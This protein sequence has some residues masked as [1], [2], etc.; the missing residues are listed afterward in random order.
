MIFEPKYKIDYSPRGDTVDTF[1]QKVKAEID[2]IYHILNALRQNFP[3]S[4]DLNDTE[5]FQ[6]HVDTASK[7]IFVRNSSNESWNVIGDIDKDY[8]GITP[9]NIGAVKSD[10]TVGKFSAGNE[11]QKPTDAKTGDIFYD[12]TNRRA[13]YYT[14]TAW[15]IFLSLNFADLYD[16]ESYCVA[17]SE[18][19]YNGKNKIPRLDKNTGKGNFDITGSPEKILG[20]TIEVANLKDNDALIFDNAKQKFVNKPKDEITKADVSNSGGAN[21]IVQTNSAGFAQV[22]ISGSAA[23]IDGVQ[24]TTAGIANQKTLCYNSTYKRFEPADKIFAD[25]TGSAEKISG[26]GLDV[27]N[28]VDQQFLVYN[29]AQKKIIS[30]KKEYLHEGDVSSTG[31]VDKIVRLD[32]AGIVH[33]NL[34]GS[35]SKIGGVSVNA[36]GIKDGQVLAYDSAQKI[37]KPV[38]KDFVTEEKISE[39]GEIGKLVRLGSD[40]TIHANVDGSVSQ[41]DGV[42]FNLEK[43]SDGQLLSYSS[44]T[45]KIVPV[46]KDTNATS[47]NTITIDTSNLQNGQVLIYDAKNKKFVPAD[48]DFFTEKDVSSTGEVGKL[49]KVAANTP[50]NVNITGSASMIDGVNV[51]AAKPDDGDILVYRKSKNSFQ[52]ESKNTTGAGKS[53]TFTKGNETVCEYNGSKEIT[54]DIAAADKLET[55]RKIKLTGHAE[56][57][58]FF[59]GTSDVELN[60]VNVTTSLADEADFAKKCA[61]LETGRKISIGGLVT[62]AATEFDGTRDISLN[63]TK[64][65]KL[66]TPRNIRFTGDITGV[67]AFDGSEDINIPI[68]V[69]QARAATTAALATAA[70]TATQDSKGNN[71]FETYATKTELE[72]SK[73]TVVDKYLEDYAKTS[74]IETTYAK[75]SEVVK[76]SDLSTEVSKLNSASADKLSSAKKI[77]LTGAVKGTVNFD[78]SENVE[79]EVTFDDSV[80]ITAAELAAI[81]YF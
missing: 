81:F 79:M 69:N 38:N 37:L 35:A 26:V 13:Y 60:V 64:V 29:A 10:G 24:V 27:A 9:E 11:N 3:A 63:V 49:I 50:L 72:N 30:D 28:L 52:L 25:I 16:Y 4:G 32:A 66:S 59:D 54:L 47:I 31:A 22:S 20:Y 55:A 33:A 51:S 12:F 65:E 21:K 39:T 80:A 8:F 76:K 44:K 74:E 42:T 70:V 36:S 23:A 75:N 68:E 57:E 15:N 5:A 58:A 78:G 48:K 56:G 53:L 61:R 34:D 67:G 43:I 73:L 6:F 77:T 41:I 46:A 17:R 45:K 7:K 2:L 18:V 1:A 40:K 19:D 71:I 14:G 62:A